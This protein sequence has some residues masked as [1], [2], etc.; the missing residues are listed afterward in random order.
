MKK[1]LVIITIAVFTVSSSFAQGEVR[2]GAKAG[3]NLASIGGDSY[4]GLG[5]FDSRTSFHIGALVEV[6]FTD[7]IS[8]QPEVMYS[9]QGSKGDFGFTS[10]GDIKLDYLT[11]PIMGKYHIIEGLSGELGPVF[12]FL[13]KAEA[14]DGETVID[15]LPKSETIDLKDQ[16]KG[17]DVAIGIG[18]TYRLP[19]G[20]FGSLRYNKGILDINDVAGYTGKNQNNVFQVSAGYTF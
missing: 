14:E 8:V 2:F 6:P 4:H 1:L 18:A 10:T 16:Y 15:P 20:L 5:G 7:K 12:S 9:S 3:L 19:F 17:F 11:L 13:V